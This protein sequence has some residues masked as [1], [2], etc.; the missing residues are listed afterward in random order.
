MAHALEEAKAHGIKTLIFTVDLPVGGL[1]YRDERSG[2]AGP[3]ANTRR[4][5]QAITRPSWTWS[6]GIMG[7]PHAPGNIAH[8]E[9]KKTGLTAYQRRVGDGFDPTISW[10]DLEW[11]RENWDGPL[12]LKGIMDPADIPDAIK[13][14]ADGIIVSNHGGRQL[15]SAPSSVV[16]LPAIL[17]AVDG[18]AKVL[19][20]GGI[21]SGL[22]AVKA[23][24]LGADAVMI[25]RSYIYALAARGEAGV[26]DLLAMYEREFRVAMT[27]IGAQTI[28]D[29]DRSKLADFG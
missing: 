3:F 29:L 22:D 9:K 14:G 8:F 24:C 20:D 17:D 21:R 26:R 25:G 2:L 19:F 11:L 18:R 13:L 6:V 1:R 23:L 4:I 15:D 7:R 10:K 12:I 28:A 16:A 27:L 5:L